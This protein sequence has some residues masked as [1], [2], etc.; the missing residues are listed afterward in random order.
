MPPF[1][2]L[3]RPVIRLLRCCL[4]GNVEIYRFVRATILVSRKSSQ[5]NSAPAHKPDSLS[6][7]PRPTFE[8]VG[9]ISSRI[10]PRF[11][12]SFGRAGVGERELLTL[13]SEESI[14]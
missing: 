14:G 8:D 7:A 9:A 11:L 5:P 6:S 12:E 13:P 10:R 2:S 3:L 4:L 1:F